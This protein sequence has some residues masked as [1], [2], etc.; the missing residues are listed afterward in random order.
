M[1]E[2]TLSK[3]HKVFSV[4]GATLRSALE[5]GKSKSSAIKSPADPAPENRTDAESELGALTPQPRTLSIPKRSAPKELVTSTQVNR[6]RVKVELLSKREKS[7]KRKEE[8]KEKE[9]PSE[10]TTIKALENYL[11]IARDK[12]SELI[13]RLAALQ[14]SQDFIEGGK[15]HFEI[16]EILRKAILEAKEKS[17]ENE[18]L[19]NENSRLRKMVENLTFKL[20]GTTGDSIYYSGHYSEADS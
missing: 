5:N 3:N 13:S 8:K 6:A 19:K 2:P 17:Q 9:S 12:N 14:Q 16:R 18:K 4:F 1:S 11:K 10:R 7:K 20:H 15:R